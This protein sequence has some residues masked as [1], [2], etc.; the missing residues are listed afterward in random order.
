[1]K[2][3]PYA[4]CDRRISIAEP[5]FIDPELAFHCI[6]GGWAHVFHLSLESTTMTNEGWSKSEIG[7]SC[8][9]PSYTT[10]DLKIISGDKRKPEV[11][12]PNLNF[13]QTIFGTI[14]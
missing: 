14:C 2:G 10:P 9:V 3:C 4:T 13:A 6:L 11:R 8:F 5:P 12:D 7:D 1:M